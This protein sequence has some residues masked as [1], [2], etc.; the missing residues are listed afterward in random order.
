MKLIR[1]W[2]R[3][4]SIESREIKEIKAGIVLPFKWRNDA[5]FLFAE[6]FP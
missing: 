6:V 2:S 4:A 5:V 3:M 1:S